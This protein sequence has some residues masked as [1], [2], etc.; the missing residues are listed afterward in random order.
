MFDIVGFIETITGLMNGSFFFFHGR[1]DIMNAENQITP[2]TLPMVLLFRPIDE[3]HEQRDSGSVHVTYTMTIAFANYKED[4]N[5]NYLQDNYDTNIIDPMR[6]AAENFLELIKQAVNA[7]GNERA[8]KIESF[9][10]QDFTNNPEF[11]MLLS[12]MLMD[13]NLKI[14]DAYSICV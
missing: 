14:L 8:A 1:P 9:T 5:K 4:Q 12:G 11:N 10:M 13:L 3:E 2:N 7:N 6:T